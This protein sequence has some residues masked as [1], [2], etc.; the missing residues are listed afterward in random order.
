MP[1]GIPNQPRKVCEDCKSPTR[2]RPTCSK[3]SGAPPAAAPEK[4]RPASRAAR[5]NEEENELAGLELEHLLELRDEVAAELQR[6]LDQAEETLQLLQQAL[7]SS[8]EEAA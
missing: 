8:T 7:K 3:Y 5:A 2:H 6:R 4:K 1:R